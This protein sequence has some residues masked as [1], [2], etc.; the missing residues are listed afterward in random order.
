MGKTGDRG[1]EITDGLKRKGMKL[2]P[3]RLEIIRLLSRDNNHPS[4]RALLRKV[5]ETMPKVSTSTVYYTL[6]MLKKEG[7][8]KELEFDNMDSRYEARMEDHIDLICEKCGAIENFDRDVADVP[9]LIEAATGFRSR[10]MRYEY[11]GFCRKCRK[12]D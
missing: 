4:A 1:Q 9:A 5:R 2:T 3:Q 12:E 11:Y 7:L 10:K 8:I 6:N